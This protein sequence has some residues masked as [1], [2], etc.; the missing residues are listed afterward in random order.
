MSLLSIGTV[1]FPKRGDQAVLE[2]NSIY[3]QAS[4]STKVDARGIALAAIF[5]W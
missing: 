1:G 3:R 4:L 2:L 5:A